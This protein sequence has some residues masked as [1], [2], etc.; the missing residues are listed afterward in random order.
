MKIIKYLLI[1][2]ISLSFGSCSDPLEVIPKNSVTFENYFRTEKDLDNVLNSVKMAFRNYCTFNAI[3]PP[4]CKGIVANK[5][6]GGG[7]GLTI[8]LWK[9]LDF[10]MAHISE[11]FSCDWKTHYIVITN[12]QV[13]I[14]N[15][16]QAE[17]P[18]ERIDFY[19][20]QAHFYQA[21][22]YFLIA[23]TWGDAPL[24]TNSRDIEPKARAPWQDVVQYALDEVEK[25]IHMLPLYQDMTDLRGTKI[26]ARDLPCKEVAY[27]LK[28]FICAWK[29]SLNN[30]PKLFEE[31]VTAATKVIESPNYSLAVNPEEVCVSV[32]LGGSM[33]ESIFE[34]PIRN[35]WRELQATG[36]AFTGAYA[37]ATF[38]VRPEALEGDIEF[39]DANIFYSTADK[40]YP[41]VAGFGTDLRRDA[42]FY[43]LDQRKDS[44]AAKGYAYPY[45]FRKARVQSSGD[46]IYEFENFDQNRIFYRLADVILLR[47]EC[48]ARQNKDGLAILDLKRVRDRAYGKATPYPMPGVDTGDLRFDI[49]KERERELIWECARYFDIIRNGYWKTEISPAYSKLTEQNIMDGALYLPI[50]SRAQERNQMALQ[51]KYWL[52]KW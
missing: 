11:N 3:Q 45:K 9:E 33:T 16:Y 2:F 31:A 38:P 34:A 13:L 22:V 17:A 47:A 14:E 30:E 36:V 19:V 6:N 50:S 25:A 23:Q 49:F 12:S 35:Y 51:N 43:Q 39:A 10:E 42:Y 29:A 18:K 21:Y 24:V 44:V 32:L 8:K 15:A 5:F 46:N 26:T 4:A 52:S 20:G 28:A 40:M 41:K 48:L 27:T 37:L 1:V 7:A